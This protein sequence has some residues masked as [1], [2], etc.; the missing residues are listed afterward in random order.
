MVEEQNKDKIK[1]NTSCI[2]G[3]PSVLYSVESGN[4]LRRA[5][6]GG[7]RIDRQDFTSHHTCCLRGA[8]GAA[9]GKPS[10][11]TLM[12]VQCVAWVR[13]AEL[14]GSFFPIEDTK[15]VVISY[16]PEC[17]Q[18][19]LCMA[20]PVKTKGTTLDFGAGNRSVDASCPPAPPS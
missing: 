20:G 16:I 8:R 15:G 13:R 4:W 2:S 12:P 19:G 9:A 6:E 18:A 17:T 7:L 10:L 3:K 5:G 11:W 14:F 1:T